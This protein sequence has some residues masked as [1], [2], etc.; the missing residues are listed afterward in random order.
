MAGH[1][2]DHK[3]D[4]NELVDDDEN[5]SAGHAGDHEQEEHLCDDA[6]VAGHKGNHNR[7]AN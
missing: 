2:G 5:D 6:D 4:V 7:D 1:K 3:R